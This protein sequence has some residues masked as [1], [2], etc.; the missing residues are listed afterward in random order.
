MTDIRIIPGSG[1]IYFSGS[2]EVTTLSV[3]ADGLLSIEGSGS[4]IFDIQGSTGQL[5]SVTDS[6]SGSL[7][8]VNDISGIPVLE[9]FSD[10]RV[11]MGQ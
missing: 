5:F 11:V 10:D 2:N 3:D 8:S 6:L 1:S 9:V 7:M 4:T